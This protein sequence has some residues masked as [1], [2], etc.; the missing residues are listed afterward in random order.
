MYVYYNANPERKSHG[1]C[2]IRALSTVMGL[3]WEQV[4]I[5]TKFSKKIYTYKP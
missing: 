2:V 1:D 5:E 4:A 3:T